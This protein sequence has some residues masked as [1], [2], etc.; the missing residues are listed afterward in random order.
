[1]IHDPSHHVNAFFQKKLIR[2]PPPSGPRRAGPT[3][4]APP[5]HKPSVLA[6]SG[7]PTPFQIRRLGPL[8][9]RR[10]VASASRTS[11]LLMA[12]LRVATD[13]NSSS[14]WTLTTA[15]E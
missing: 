9:L 2:D 10:K 3:Q 6:V 8:F 13:A 4:A 1:M 15:P 14:T 11:A 7:A 5:A 12:S